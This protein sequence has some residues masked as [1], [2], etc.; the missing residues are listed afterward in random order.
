MTKLKSDRTDIVDGHYVSPLRE[1]L[2][3][4]LMDPYQAQIPGGL[5]SELSLEMGV[6][7][8]NLSHQLRK[9]IREEIV[10]ADRYGQRI[11]KVWIIE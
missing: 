10:G 9:L 11:D 4:Y 6:S 8:D 7:R 3:A 2:L 5:T 1:R